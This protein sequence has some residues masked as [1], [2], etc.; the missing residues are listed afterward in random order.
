MVTEGFLMLTKKVLSLFSLT[1][2]L[3]LNVQALP[4][5]KAYTDAH[6]DIGVRFNG[7][8]LEGFWLNDAATVNGV[9][10][11]ADQNFDEHAIRALGVFDDA[12]PPLI[13]PVGSQWDFLGMDA[14]EPLYFF[15]SGGEPNTLPYLGFS[16]EDASLP[17]LTTNHGVDKFVVTLIDMVGP[18]GS[19]FSIF[20]S[21]S[22]IRVATTNGFP[23]GYVELSPGDHEHFNFG[24]SHIGTYDLVFRL[25]AISNGQVLH[26]FT[27]ETI[28][29]CQITEGGGYLNYD[30]WRR[31]LFT[32][33]DF[34]NEA[35]SGKSADPVGDGRSNLHRYAFGEFPVHDFIWVEH[36]GKTY[37]ALRLTQRIGTEDLSLHVESSTDL[38]SWQEANVVLHENEG[39]VF[40]NPGLET[41][42]YRITDE[43]NPRAFLRARAEMM[44]E[45]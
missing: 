7:A 37:P 28:V 5:F 16:S 4:Q 23:A 21:A 44:A 35:I 30:Q 26:Q 39:R 34:G 18:S 13:R 19:A 10:T 3:C 27:G 20:R 1:F 40:H 15:P 2:A 24:F 9:I 17:Y 8:T 41:R 11:S 14:G 43:S 36:E 22:D 32:L 38:Q 31:T 42:I 25:E 29:R 12:T 33:N 45:P 6:M